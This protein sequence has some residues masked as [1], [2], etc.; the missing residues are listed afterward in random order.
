MNSSESQQPRPMLRR[1][2]TKSKIQSAS[3]DDQALFLT[4]AHVVN[5]INA[6]L[7]AAEWS[8]DFSS[9]I[10]AKVD[11]QITLSLM[12][13]KLLAGKLNEA[14][15]VI[16]GAYF[17]SALS[18]TYNARLQP[19]AVNALNALKKYFDRENNVHRI[20]NNFAFHYSHEELRQVF[21]SVSETL[22]VYMQRDGAPNNLFYFA[23]VV[24]A[25]ALFRTIGIPNNEDA[26]T[27]L[28]SELIDVASNFATLFDDLIGAFLETLGQDAWQAQA[29][30]VVFDELPLFDDIHIPWF[31]NASAL[32]S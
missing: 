4:I 6:L 8:S 1:E 26:L 3:A 21:P 31:T 17:R 19:D 28:S 25:E 27:T 30:P 32:N 18:K 12:F 7:R 15:Q 10:Q 20:R 14:Y 22:V 16:Q 13:F 23:E 2:I 24:T 5:E 9:P 11:G 29:Q